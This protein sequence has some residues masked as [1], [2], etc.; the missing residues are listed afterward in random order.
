MSY[1]LKEPEF[2]RSATTGHL[3]F[4]FLFGVVVTIA[5]IINYMIK[6]CWSVPMTSDCGDIIPHVL[7]LK[8]PSL[9]IYPALSGFLNYGYGFSFLD[10][11]W[12][13][14]WFSRKLTDWS[15]VSPLS[16][17]LTYLNMNIASTYLLAL[18]IFIAIL[19]LTKL[20]S[21]L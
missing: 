4:Y 1:N 15:D 17:R 11:P 8:V 6:I 18:L 2:Q 12:L 14:T 16:F 19:A 7:L 5:L 20:V 9:L 10:F 21:F 3:Y 13:N